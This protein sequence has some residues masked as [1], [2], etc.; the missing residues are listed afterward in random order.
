MKASI[1]IC[2]FTIAVAFLITVAF[3]IFF[4]GL[5]KVI[6]IHKIIARV[7]WRVNVNHLDFTHVG[8]L[9]QFQNFEVIALNIKILCMLPVHALFWARAQC[10]VDRCSSLL[11]GSTLAHPSKVIDFRSILHRLVA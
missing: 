5:R 10:L 7:I 6:M 1:A 4:C 9:E 11:Q 8:V 3:I 2:V